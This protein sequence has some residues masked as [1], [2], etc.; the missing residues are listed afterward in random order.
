MGNQGKSAPS[1]CIFWG[2]V[3][4]KHSFPLF[5]HV[6]C[7]PVRNTGAPSVNKSEGQVCKSPRKIFGFFACFLMFFVL[8]MGSCLGDRLLWR[9]RDWLK[10]CTALAADGQACQQFAQWG[11]LKFVENEL[12][13]SQ[14]R[15]LR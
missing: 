2:F 5:W 10:L 15:L 14:D 3:H 1:V 13:R 6:L 8:L 7:L 12:L 4:F 9:E 11:L